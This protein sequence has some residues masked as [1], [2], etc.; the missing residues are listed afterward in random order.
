[1]NVYKLFEVCK[2]FEANVYILLSNKLIENDSRHIHNV[3]KD[4]SN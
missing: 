2:I 4:V 3:T 1:M